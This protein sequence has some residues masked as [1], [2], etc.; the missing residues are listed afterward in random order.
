[1]N[2]NQEALKTGIYAQKMNTKTTKYQN[3]PQIITESLREAILEGELPAGSRLKQIQIAEQYGASLIPVREALRTLEQEGL[4][5]LIPNKGALVSALS[6]REVAD[7]FGTRIILE[8]G[9]FE[10][11]CPKLDKED[12]A[13]CNDLIDQL[14]AAT[15]SNQ[16]SSLNRELHTCLYRHCDNV[17]LLELIHT[18]HSNVERYMR[19][20]LKEHYNNDLSQDY[21]RK[22]VNAVTKSEFLLSSQL[23][24]K[25]MEMAQENL[26]QAL[27][28][29]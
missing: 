8:I 29:Q 11:S 26:T 2:D 7:I 17:Y 14:D 1:M 15:T 5:T 10:L 22:I 4:V 19:L 28:K 12:L 25:H 27:A 13:E 23:L 24:A 16:L 21:H 18:L 3:L 20:Y 9:A 6:A